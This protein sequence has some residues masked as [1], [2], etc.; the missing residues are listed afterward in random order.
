MQT[1][2]AHDLSSFP[3][4]GMSSERRGIRSPSHRAALAL[5]WACITTAAGQA[6]A[7]PPPANP[8]LPLHR[9]EGAW[10]VMARGKP[11]PDRLVNDCAQ[12]G[13][14]FACQQTLNGTPGPLVVFIPETAGRYHTQVVQGDGSAVGP[15]GTLTIE[16]N[17]WVYL[18]RADA[19]GV[20][21]RTT[22]DF[23]GAGR[24]RFAVARSRDGRKW[25]VTLSGVEER[26][27]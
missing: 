22:N 9:Y 25:L 12:V 26:S 16:G 20:R 24:I 19:Q 15:P 5:V 27:R 11:A 14:F 1:G 4:A 18:S 10:S 17:H 21:Y 2:A 7:G 13:R 8:Y 3:C 23:D 6:V